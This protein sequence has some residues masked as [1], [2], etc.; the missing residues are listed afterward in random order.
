MTTIDTATPITA[1]ARRIARRTQL[2]VKGMFVCYFDREGLLID[3]HLSGL[4]YADPADR[5]TYAIRTIS[6]PMTKRE[7]QDLLDAYDAHPDDPLAR[8]EYLSDL[9]AARHREAGR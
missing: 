1:A 4:A 5:P 2:A 6:G 9:E 7:A 8:D 3:T